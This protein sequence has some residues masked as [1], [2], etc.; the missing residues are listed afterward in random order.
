MGAGILL[1]NVAPGLVEAIAAAEVAS[2]NLV[3]AVLISAMVYPMIVGVD[4]RSLRS[5]A[6]AT[7]RIDNQ[8]C[9][10]MAD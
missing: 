5:V 7:A 10:E 4:S 8:S 9:Q 1:G 3:V 6:K 2:V